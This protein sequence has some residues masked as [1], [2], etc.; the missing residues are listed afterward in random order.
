M[1]NVSE[2]YC[3]TKA[4]GIWEGVVGSEKHDSGVS[5]DW[6]PTTVLPIPS[7]VTLA[8]LLNISELQFPQVNIESNNIFL[9]MFL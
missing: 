9:I 6:V 2:R 4:K 7:F 8:K 3:I 1:W 5:L